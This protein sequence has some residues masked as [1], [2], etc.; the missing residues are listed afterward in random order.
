MTEILDTAGLVVGDSIQVIAY[1]SKV[2]VISNMTQ[3]G[4]F[5]EVYHLNGEFSSY[6]DGI[7]FRQRGEAL[8]DPDMFNRM[9]V[10]VSGTV[11]M[12]KNALQ[13]NISEIR[14]LINDIEVSELLATIGN[15][16]LINQLSDIVYQGGSM[17]SFTA[18]IFVSA[19]GMIDKGIAE[20]P[21][22]LYKFLDIA[23]RHYPDEFKLYVDNLAVIIDY[24]A[25]KE[26][27]TADKIDT[28]VHSNSPFMVELLFR[29]GEFPE[30]KEVADL[31]HLIMKL[32]G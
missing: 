15:Q 5:R 2:E 21:T 12:Y 29:E 32:K 13:L 14:S 8:V 28:L 22:R 1:C 25:N 19:E 7:I 6:M 16:E 4:T 10:L 27:T 18:D 11:G 20:M 3:V 30:Y 9:P 17:Y 31:H 24:I 26:G 23:Q